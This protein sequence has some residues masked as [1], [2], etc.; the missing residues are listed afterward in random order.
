MLSLPPSVR[1]FLCTERTDMRRS[2]DGLR[3]LAEEV[4]RQD[5]FSGHLFVFCNRR[6]DR[7]KILYWARG[8]FAIWYTRLEEGVFE[9]PV[10]DA[11]GSVE[12]EA[13]ELSL[14]LEGIELSSARRR[15]RYQLPAGAGRL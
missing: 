2:F 9:F 12:V 11:S 6:G 8:G 5:P 3:M 15:R 14:L 1:V 7:L 10:P 4:C 13:S